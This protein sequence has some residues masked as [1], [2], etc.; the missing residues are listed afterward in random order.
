MINHPGHICRFQ[1]EYRT[2]LGL[3]Y[4]CS[5]FVSTLCN[6]EKSRQVHPHS[7][8]KKA[9]KPTCKS[10]VLPMFNMKL[11]SSFY[12]PIPLIP[13]IMLNLC[14]THPAA[15]Q[16]RCYST[17]RLLTI[18]L[19]E[20]PLWL[21]HTWSWHYTID[22]IHFLSFPFH[23][24][25]HDHDAGSLHTSHTLG[26]CWCWFSSCDCWVLYIHSCSACLSQ[27][28]TSHDLSIWLFLVISFAPYY[29]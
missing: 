12:Y 13:D 21:I 1:V 5:S 17:I 25:Q 14:Y 26:L 16:S 28:A 18:L 24:I 22:S 6:L 20:I 11:T 10:P 7:L 23:F 9:L 2:I 15:I 27:Y 29:M 19:Y 8:S 3:K 4:L